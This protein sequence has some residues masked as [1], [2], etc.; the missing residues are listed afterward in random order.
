VVILSVALGSTVFLFSG[1]GY[2]GFIYFLLLA[3][4]NVMSI[5]KLFNLVVTKNFVLS[6]TSVRI[7]KVSFMR[8]KDL[9][10]DI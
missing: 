10:L 8:C 3:Y 9:F 6:R 5:D 7:R 2:G 4:N 1:V